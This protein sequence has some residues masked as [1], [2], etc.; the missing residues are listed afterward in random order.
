MTDSH[1][2]IT[3]KARGICKYY[4]T[5]RG[6]F[7][8]NSCKF[9]HSTDPAIDSSGSRAP[10]LTPY[11]QA[12]RC[13]YY[14]QGYCKR[15]DKCWFIHEKSVPGG[16]AEDADDDCCSICF[17][18]PSLYGLLSGCN[19]AFCIDCIRKWRDPSGKGP[20]T[21]NIKKCPLCR[22]NCCYII[23]SSRFVKD[24]PEKERIIQN[25][26]D[27][28]ARVPCE[29]F[30]ATKV[31]NP[32]KPLC[33]YGA[34]CFY[35]HLN[36]DGT[37]YIF[38]YGVKIAL[39]NWVH[40]N[41]SHNR[42]LFSF[43][44]DD[45]DPVFEEDAALADII[46]MLTQ[47]MESSMEGRG[48][49]SGRDSNNNRR[50]RFRGPESALEFLSALRAHAGILGGDSGEDTIRPA[51][52]QEAMVPSNWNLEGD[53]I[54][55]GW[56]WNELVADIAGNNVNFTERLISQADM[57]GSPRNV[58]GRDTGSPVPPFE[59]TNIP[60]QETP[61][62]LEP[63]DARGISQV[64]QDDDDDMPA[65]QSVSNSSDSE[66]SDDGSDGEPNRYSGYDPPDDLPPLEIVAQLD[67]ETRSSF[68]RR[69]STVVER[70]RES[71]EGIE[72]MEEQ[73]A[74]VSQDTSALTSAEATLE[75]S[76]TST[77]DVHTLE[78]TQQPAAT[79]HP[80][81]ALEPPF[82]TDGRGRVVWS[83]K[84]STEA[85]TASGTREE[86][87]EDV[88]RPSSAARLFEWM[89]GFF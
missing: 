74:E 27:S 82:V 68:G 38:P 83:N 59:P 40:R 21:S 37:P 11:D 64:S 89:S 60:R 30:L 6:C 45:L 7:N 17:E 66:N 52:V 49:G 41:H 88:Q 48:A 9:L 70:E 43:I 5:E 29:H 57:L 69:F 51:I 65:L 36:D 39:R 2:P 73:E 85:T 23:P 1:R 42:R 19:H 28:M 31:K 14:V 86:P 80:E 87:R 35:Q 54:D 34:D 58:R 24:G 33:P 8:A 3:S 4:T 61:P 75:G 25:Y 53:E 63:T 26:K 76:E 22:A 47:A 13:K 46:G 62:P 16:K 67:E 15:G 81:P 32:K 78:G 56:G 18:T 77:Q 44:P 84:D 12:K 72:T 79:P 50:R 71:I 20:D 10:L 55:N